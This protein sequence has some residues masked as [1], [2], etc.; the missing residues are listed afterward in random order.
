[1]KPGAQLA[2]GREAA[3]WR[4]GW[5]WAGG[6]DVPTKHSSSV[7]TWT[8]TTVF[9]FFQT[10]PGARETWDPDIPTRHGSPDM[11]PLP[12]SQP[13]C[14][15]MPHS[16]RTLPSYWPLLTEPNTGRGKVRAGVEELQEGRSGGEE[17][18][19][20]IHT[21]MHG[22]AH[23]QTRAHTPEVLSPPEWTSWPCSICL[24]LPRL[25]C[26]LGFSR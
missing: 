4:R 15:W 9:Q 8:D 21:Y 2:E 18:Q 11:V 17:G 10:A 3:G 23:S 5:S 6:E 22:C 20:H 19:A 14:N 1:M 26:C 16:P 24:D 13:Q 7:W 25:V 12:A